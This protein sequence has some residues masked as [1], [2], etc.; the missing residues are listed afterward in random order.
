MRNAPTK[1]SLFILIGISISACNTLKR[2][3]DSKKLLTKNEIIVN[4]KKVKT[5]NITNLLYQKPN[6]SILGFHLRLHLYN[7]AK[8]NHDSI[9]KAKFINHPEKY[10]RKSKWLSAKQVNRLGQSFWY[11]GIHDFL[12]DTGEPPVIIDKKS[13]DKSNQRL[14]SHY[15]NNGYFEVKTSDKYWQ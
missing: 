9:Y 15:F 2:V 12:R 5:D 1:I 4:D 11:G 7:L 8:L 3:P 10:R 6:T 14:K 13:A